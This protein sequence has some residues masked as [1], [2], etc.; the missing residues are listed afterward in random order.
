ML[1]PY[2]SKSQDFSWTSA[3]I[4]STPRILRYNQLQESILGKFHKRACSRFRDEE[5]GD[6]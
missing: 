5:I 1:C 4:A 6:K 2:T 3:L